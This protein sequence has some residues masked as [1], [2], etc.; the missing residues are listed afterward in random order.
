MEANEGPPMVKDCMTRASEQKDAPLE[1]ILRVSEHQPH[2]L[3]IPTRAPE[4]QPLLLENISGADERHRP[5][6]WFPTEA[7]G[8]RAHVLENISGA[9]ERQAPP[10]DI[11]VGAQK[12][13][14]PMFPTGNNSARQASAAVGFHFIG[15]WIAVAHKKVSDGSESAFWAPI[16]F[17]FTSK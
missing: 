16:R 13:T 11:R 14:P 10:S 9:N 12:H 1:T 5:I 17:Q 2:L 3:D 6:K 7:N 15:R 8:R 4:C